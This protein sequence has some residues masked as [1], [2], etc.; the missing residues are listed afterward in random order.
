MKHPILILIASLLFAVSAYSEPVKM[1]FDT[2]MGG[3]IDD[4][5]ALAVI[6][7]LQNRGEVEL[8]AV[9]CSKDHPAA[10]S[11][12]DIINTWFGRGNIPIGRVVDGKTPAPGKY[13]KQ[14]VAD[15]FPHDITP[16]TETP[17]AVALLRKTLAAQPDGS[18]VL[19]LVG[20]QTNVAR[21]LES[22][23]D[24]HSPLTGRALV[25]QKVRMLSVMAGMFSNSKKGRVNVTWNVKVDIDAAR[26][27]MHE[28]PTKIVVTPF[29]L[30]NQ[31]P[32]PGASIERDFSKKNPVAA[33]YRH[34][35]KMP[36]DRP[37]WDLVSVLY[38]SRAT[39]GYFNETARG[40]V[41]V[42]E[43]GRT[44]FKEAPDGN[45]IILSATPAQ[46]ARIIKS[47][48]ELASDHPK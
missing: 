8:L 46:R 18:V 20:Q 26:T 37:G 25:K 14:T 36:Y 24:K 21:L 22:R 7:G 28:W 43:A 47:F 30:G 13:L 4:V 39:R 6:H 42:D 44:K 38:P 17:E 15:G 2:D 12:V 19:V 33:A 31:L 34:W 27:V 1:I 35:G 11:V 40:R 45:T 48:I 32:Y 3:D 29:R 10:A 41:T 16:Q 23:P 9:T 5:L